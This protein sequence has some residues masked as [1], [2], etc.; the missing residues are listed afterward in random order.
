[1]DSLNA[2]QMLCN[3]DIQ[4]RSHSYE[5]ANRILTLIGNNL[6]ASFCIPISKDYNKSYAHNTA[7]FFVTEHYDHPEPLI[8]KTIRHF[9]HRWSFIISSISPLDF[10]GNINGLIKKERKFNDFVYVFL[11]SLGNA[12]S[13]LSDDDILHNFSLIQKFF[14]NVYPSK[15]SEIPKSIWQVIG[16]FSPE[17]EIMQILQ[18]NMDIQFTSIA[19]IL[20]QKNPMK[21]TNYLFKEASSD[22][23]N[24]FLKNCPQSY[25]I[26]INEIITRVSNLT[27]EQ[28]N[29]I[30]T[31]LNKIYTFLTDEKIVPSDINCILSTL[32]EGARKNLFERDQLK[33]F[34]PKIQFT[35]DCPQLQITFLKISILCM[36]K[37]SD[38]MNASKTILSIHPW[39]GQIY[40]QYFTL[41]H[42]TY[43]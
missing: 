20:I 25:R 27:E 17:N 2:Y 39:F 18:K 32:Y 29:Q 35:E 8:Q 13:L 5:N 11:P 3:F 1:M 21:Y 37:D 9:I 28:K 41:F 30:T 10:L 15:Q 40:I 33:K 43:K 14:H 26:D 36:D 42:L 12:I 16:K 19:P 34:L 24:E 6:K 38:N 4:L 31:I 23:L 7:F 22:F